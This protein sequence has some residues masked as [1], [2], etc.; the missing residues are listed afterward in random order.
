M[1]LD[2]LYNISVIIM[3]VSVGKNSSGEVNASGDNVNIPVL[4]EEAS[5]IGAVSISCGAFEVCAVV[6]TSY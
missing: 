5:G 2:E 6:I 1:Y 4:V 3:G